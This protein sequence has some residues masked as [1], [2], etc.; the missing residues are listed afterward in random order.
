MNP[1]E[2]NDSVAVGDTPLVQHPRRRGSLP[3]KKRFYHEAMG[4]SSAEQ[5]EASSPQGTSALSSPFPPLHAASSVNRCSKMSALMKVAASPNVYRKVEGFRG[6]SLSV[7]SS[8]PTVSSSEGSFSA[9][10]VSTATE[11]GVASNSF[12]DSLSFRSFKRPKPALKSANR[13]TVSPLVPAKRVATAAG[14][15]DRRYTGG[16][17]ERRCTATTTRGNDCAYVALSGI[18]FCRLHENSQHLRKEGKRCA[19]DG[20]SSSTPKSK[21]SSLSSSN[22]QLL[23]MIATDKWQGKRVRIGSGPFKNRHGLVLKWGNGW[24]TVKI[25][26]TGCHNRRAFDLYLVPSSTTTTST[27]KL[28][29]TLKLTAPKMKAA[30]SAPASPGSASESPGPAF[31]PIRTSSVTC[32]TVSPS[33]VPAMIENQINIQDSVDGIPFMNTPTAPKFLS[34]SALDQL[35]SVPDI[36]TKS[37]WSGDRPDSIHELVRLRAQHS[38]HLLFGSAALDRGR[39]P[40]K[41]VARFPGDE[42]TGEE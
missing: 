5:G 39:R 3:F 38:R 33:P 26:G 41:K 28:T 7:F 22:S 12:D 42:E 35:P 14:L 25:P 16:P 8:L 21:A 13:V 40:M 11:E 32:S 31:S 20:S 34:L 36:T 30:P 10:D 23:S 24:V 17:G 29:P 2:T 9:S 37:T 15:Q 18:P 19:V 4:S 1:Q 27:L 6:Q